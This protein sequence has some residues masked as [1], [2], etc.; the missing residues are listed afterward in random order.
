MHGPRCLE[1]V[2]TNSSGMKITPRLTQK[3][4]WPLK[5]SP[6]GKI[7]FP[8]LWTQPCLLRTCQYLHLHL[9]LPI[10]PALPH[11]CPLPPCLPALFSL[12][13][14]P[15]QLVHHLLFSTSG[16]NRTW[17]SP[18]NRGSP[19]D[20]KTPIHP[21]HLNRGSHLHQLFEDPTRDASNDPC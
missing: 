18:S 9:H 4:S 5:P 6:P 10:L 12:L 3:T 13:C 21:T 20:L 14:L 8:R 7:E 19:Q 11:L 1:T 17:L 16:R 2:S 15:P